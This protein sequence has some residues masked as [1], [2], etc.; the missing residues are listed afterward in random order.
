MS[1]AMTLSIRLVRRAAVACV[2]AWA[3]CAGPA[4]AALVLN[5]T[6]VVF[7]EHTRDVTIRLDNVEHQPV[8]AQTWIDDGRVEVPPEQMRTPFVVAPSLMRVEPG[9]GA[10]LRITSLN[11]SLPADRESLY[12][13]NVL[14]APVAR[15]DADHHLRFGFRTR[16]K[17]FYRPAALAEGIDLAPEQLVWKAF[18]QDS[19]DAGPDLALEVSN[20]TPY[21]VSFGRVESDPGGHFVSAGGGMVP[22]FGSARFRFTG[23]TSP[24]KRPTTVR[25]MVID[26]Y[27]G[28]STITKKLAN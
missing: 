2:V 12:W 24:S 15:E 26:D 11:E 4:Q 19:P 23:I 17:L 16:I 10:V 9:R 3:A 14:E 1:H 21:Y 8:L 28:R 20:P 18:A 27:G 5:G 25:Y 13:L 22:P 7:P 6:R